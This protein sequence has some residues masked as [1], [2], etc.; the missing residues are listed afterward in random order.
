MLVSR[1]TQRLGR[2]RAGLAGQADR[3]PEPDAARRPPPKPRAARQPAP[4]VPRPLRRR[5]PARRCSAASRPR[6][7]ASS[8][9][10]AR[11]APGATIRLYLND[12]LPGARR[13]PRRT[14][15]GPSPSRGASSP[16]TTGSA[17]TM[18]TRRAAR[19]CRAPRWPFDFAPKVASASSRSPP[20]RP[21]RPATR[22]RLGSTPPGRR[23]SVASTVPSS[24][25]VGP[26]VVVDEI[27]DPTVRAA[28]ACGAS[29]SASTA[30]ACAIR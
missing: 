19:C 23:R 22:H 21:V 27:R 12:T 28:T 13:R 4:G 25:A 20:A 8:S 6:T 15:A 24:A 16:A 1:A 3:D 2:R 29:A 5:A 10:P 26:D 11:R 7:A 14:G 9:P 17:S 18:S 30:R